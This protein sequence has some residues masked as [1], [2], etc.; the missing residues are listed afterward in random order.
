MSELV[1]QPVSS[2]DA[3]LYLLLVVTSDEQVAVGRI[4]LTVTGG[5][6]DASGATRL[7]NVSR[8]LGSLPLL[9][10]F[11]LFLSYIGRQY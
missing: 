2:A 5:A 1:V 3:G 10:F 8:G 4:T 6:P 9:L 11:R 7:A